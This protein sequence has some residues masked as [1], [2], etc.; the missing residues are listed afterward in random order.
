MKNMCWD[1]TKKIFF[2]RERE[3][4]ANQT[5]FDMVLRENLRTSVELEI[6]IILEFSSKKGMIKSDKYC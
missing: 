5:L 3:K 6:T 4:E 1:I 2:E